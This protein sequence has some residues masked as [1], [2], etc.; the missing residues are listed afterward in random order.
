ML[1]TALS[2]TS[3]SAIGLSGLRAAQTRL[4]TAAHNLANAQTPGFRWHVVQ[5]GLCCTNEA[6]RSARIGRTQGRPFAWMSQPTVSLACLAR[7]RRAPRIRCLRGGA[8][9]RFRLQPRALAAVYART[10]PSR[11]AVHL[12]QARPIFVCWYSNADNI[13][14]P[15]FTATLAGADSRHLDGVPHVAMAF[16]PTV[17]ATSLAMLA[18]GGSS[19]SERTA[20]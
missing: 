2:R 15:A 1:V 11:P 13:V 4:D 10:A 6:A 8:A 14:F 16:Y 5:Q 9:A 3:A 19:P 17:M 7:C 12:G 20:A 18:S